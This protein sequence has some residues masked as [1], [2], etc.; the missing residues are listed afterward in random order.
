M[1]KGLLL[2]AIL[3]L[4][5]CVI[6]LLPVISVPITGHNSKYAIYFAKYNGIA[7]GVFG[8]CD[9]M[10]DHCSSPHIGYPLEPSFMSKGAGIELPSDARYSISKLLIVH[11]VAFGLSC[12]SIIASYG[13][14]IM[15]YIRQRWRDKQ[16]KD[17]SQNINL[18]NYNDLET[19]SVSTKVARGIN[20]IP[21]LNVELVLS[22]LSSLFTLLGLL[23]D[24]LLFT[25]N[26]SYLGWIQIIP[27]ICLAILVSMVCFIRRS[28]FSR[29]HLDEDYFFPNDDMKERHNLQVIPPIDTSSDDGFHVYTHGF[30][31]RYDDSNYSEQPASSS[32]A[33]DT[34]ISS[35]QENSNL[36]QI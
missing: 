25:P 31:S 11:V 36:D 21:F 23:S 1:N 32:V 35:N 34:L 15:V 10:D 30:Y 24:I 19:R 2:I 3:S 13:M 27:V 4:I 33:Q 18:Q 14:I 7:F 17:M 22:I 9:Y 5:S 8:L 12:I 20:L 26:L 16:I 29:R 28:I 6:Q